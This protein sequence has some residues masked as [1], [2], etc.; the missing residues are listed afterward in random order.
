MNLLQ[1][2]DTR[3]ALRHPDLSSFNGR[4][5]AY[6]VDVRLCRSCINQSFH[7]SHNRNQTKHENQ[8]VYCL[9]EKLIEN[10]ARVCV[11]IFSP[12]NFFTSIYRFCWFVSLYMH[13]WNSV[14]RLP[15]THIGS[16]WWIQNG[17]LKVVKRPKSGFPP[18][19]CFPTGGRRPTPSLWPYFFMIPFGKSKSPKA[20][21]QQFIRV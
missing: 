6:L 19:A 17:R 3:W 13:T 7:S 10:S 20:I 2:L 9:G 4:F 14:G 15:P 1:E 5:D 11:H 12:S 16:E 21:E 8:C 18:P